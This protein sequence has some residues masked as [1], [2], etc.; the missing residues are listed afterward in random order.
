MS[1][2]LF[3]V[4]HGEAEGSGSGVLLGA[5][6]L[7]LSEAGRCQSR[8]LRQMLPVAGSVDFVSSP[9]SRARETAE[10]VIAGSG[11]R[12]RLDPDLREIDFGEWEGS[13]YS[14]VEAMVPS[15]AVEWRELREG[16]AFPGGESLS[17]FHSRM[18]RVARRLAEADADTAVVF[19]HGG[20]V[21]ALLCHFLGISFR[22]YLLFDIGPGSVSTMRLWDNGR[23]VLVGLRQAETPPRATRR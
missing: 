19:T 14:E 5:T 18:I 2:H 7:P 10:I 11:A 22:N 20:V 21:R 6:D 1:R 12:L 4:R 23:G 15:L 16:F 13:T 9:L 8:L 17:D 3:L